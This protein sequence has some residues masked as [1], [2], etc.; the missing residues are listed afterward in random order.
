MDRNVFIVQP[1]KGIN[2]LPAQNFGTP[3]YVYEGPPVNFNIST[4]VRT[5]QKSLKN[6]KKG[7]C[8]ILVGDPILMAL[9]AIEFYEVTEGDFTLL[10]WDRQTMTYYPL[11][12]VYDFHEH[13]ENPK[14]KENE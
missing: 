8:L 3:K 5:I 7:D 12:V 13:H 6:A 14:E 2:I 11:G 9:V 10:K 4:V 1:V